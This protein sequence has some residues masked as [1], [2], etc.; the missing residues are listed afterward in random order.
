MCPLN[1]GLTVVPSQRRMQFAHKHFI[2]TRNSNVT[3][4]VRAKNNSSERE[5]VRDRGSQFQ[6]YF[7]SFSTPFI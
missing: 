6:V 5:H 4:V 3:S 1:T 7:R 2:G